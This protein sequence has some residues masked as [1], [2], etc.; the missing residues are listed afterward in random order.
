MRCWCPGTGGSTQANSVDLRERSVAAR[1][2]GEP[3]NVVA[4]R[5]RVSACTVERYVRQQTMT[6]SISPRRHPGPQRRLTSEADRQLLTLRRLHPTATLAE[7]CVLL[8]RTTEI[9]LS[10]ATMVRSIARLG[11]TRKQRRW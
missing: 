9:R 10:I 6:G 3:T 1:L 7:H 4:A 2:A 11:W 5:F 8:E